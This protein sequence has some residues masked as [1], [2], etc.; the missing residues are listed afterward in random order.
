M[1]LTLIT[2][3]HQ[4][5]KSRRLWE[6]LRAQPP[7]TAV[8][9]RPGGVSRELLA[10]VH[11]WF[12]PGWLPVVLSMPEL[13]ER[14]AAALGDVP[15]AF[16]PA[17]LSHALRQWLPTGLAGSPWAPLAPYRRTANEFAD[18]LLRLDAQ[19]VADD[20]LT[21][22]ARRCEGSLS[23]KIRVVLRAR[24]WLRDE[25]RQRGATTPGARWE[26]L[27]G[28]PV[29]WSVIA[30]DDVLALTPAEIAWVADLARQRQVLMSAIDDDRCAGGLLEYVRRMIPEASE[31]R[32]SGIHAQAPFADAQRLLLPA[33]LPPGGEAPPL[34][35]GSVGGLDRYRYR[36]PVHAGRALA[37]WLDARQVPAAAV[38]IYLRTCDEQALALA[39][40]LRGA[41]LKVRGRFHLAYGATAE[42]AA[43]AALGRCLARP[44]WTAF[45]ALALRL[46]LLSAARLPAARLPD[47]QRQAPPTPLLELEGPWQGIDEAL[48]AL[49]VLAE[50]GSHD[51]LLV[52]G[53]LR[54][55]LAA[56]VVW[57]RAL[58]ARLPTSGAWFARL[59]AAA[60]DLDIALGP[61]GPALAALD[62]FFPV[63]DEDL[64]EALADAAVEIVRDDGPDSLAILDAVR[65]RS[66]PRPI[67][68]L[69]G[70]EHGR[71][72]AQPQVGVLLSPEDRSQLSPEWFDDR[73]REAGEVASVLA[74]AARGLTR[75][76]IG[77]PCGERQ[78][79]A[80]LATLAEQAELAGDDTWR[81]DALRGAPD[82][83]AVAGAP[84]GPADSQGAYE[85]A[86]WPLAGI[87]ALSPPTLEF[88]V[89]ACPPEALRLRVSSLDLALGDSFGLVC[90]RLALGGVLRDGAL[91]DDGSI[92]HELF[93][94]LAEYPVGQWREAF[95]RLLETWISSAPD[96]LARAAR[97]QRAP[98]L[99]EV[100]SAEAT[101]ASDAQVRAEYEVAVTLDLGEL[102]VLTLPGRADRLDR[103]ADG[104]LTVVDYKRGR[105]TALA[106]KVAEQREAQV[107]GYV[108]ALRGQGEQVREGVFVPLA[109]GK[110]VAIEGD[111][112]LV[113][114]AQ[115]CAAVARLAQG[116]AVARID[117][118]CPPAVI[119]ALEYADDARDPEDRA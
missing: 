58:Q 70:L 10:Q 79:S 84:L 18:L 36:D 51:D 45:R 74:C 27:A 53:P 3:P 69:H 109:G 55:G 98:R 75:L 117:G 29:P 39:D 85:Q 33:L 92:L 9:V 100:V 2:G 73:G 15:Q 38:N 86:L 103:H 96:A 37:A 4:S 16:S 17:W 35:A 32:L 115:V 26:H 13:A 44:S 52:A 118:V 63:S 31:E 65:G 95:E 46:P 14:A 24:Q 64:S 54:V 113:R 1:S 19:G 89:P 40:A 108:Q 107:L 93:A 21:L 104:S 90:Q 48:N 34:P 91:M 22:T 102:G 7:G 81:L 71:W 23:D 62:G 101:A 88:R 57:L 6:L 60:A 5:G 50:C 12:G 80:W 30:F 11:A 28:A 47:A 77:I 110:R 56:T 114:W 67:A 42:G 25:G 119:R 111:E 83:E 68:V 112:T 66:L 59:T 116:T 78:P 8:L 99:R 106:T 76:V 72:P 87:A 20:E 105:S 61:V 97:R 94:K 43:V 41:G 49:Q 82:A